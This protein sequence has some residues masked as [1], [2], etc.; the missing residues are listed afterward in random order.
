MARLL[1]KVAIVTGSASGIG[2]A[3][4]TIMAREGAKVVVADYNIDGAET[5]AETIKRNGGEAHAMF[6]DATKE[7]SV[8]EV[9][10]KSRE[11]YGSVN[12]MHNNVGGTVP[13]KDIDAAGLDLGAWDAIFDLCLKSALYGC[14]QVIP[15]MLEGG[16]GAIVNTASMAGESGDQTLTAYSAAKAGVI[17][18]T[19]SVATQYGKRNIR[20]NAVAPGLIL[21]ELSRKIIPPNVE[22]IFETHNLVP[23]NGKPEDIGHT[24]A[25]LASDDA[26]FITGQTIVV[27]G[28]MFIHNPTLVDMLKLGA[29]I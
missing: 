18:L 13:G 21:T 17:S 28:G 6:L 29:K 7:E 25:F 16:G 14:R 3:T 2:R 5:V 11:R 26:G 4:A 24:V 12:V 23:R 20:C 15:I 9:V 19:R 22:R 10:A 27:D 8:R 1:G